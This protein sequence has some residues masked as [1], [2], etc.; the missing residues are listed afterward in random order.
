M[1]NHAGGI[2]IITFIVA[3]AVSLGY[4][5]FIYIPQAN[6]KPI[7]PDNVLHPPK[8]TNIKIW[9]GASNPTQQRNFDPKSVRVSLGVDSKIV[10]TNT[11]SVAHTVTSDNKYVDLISG[12]FNSLEHLDTT[13]NGFV[14]PGKTFEFIFTT[15]GDYSYHCEP[16]PWM[17]GKISVVRSFV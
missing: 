6:A 3:V 7:L 1:D 9:A 14:N 12:P 10:W 13:G 15:D 16:H 4:Y 5:Q 2:S 17:Q 8:T 11:D